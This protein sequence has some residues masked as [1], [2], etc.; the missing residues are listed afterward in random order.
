[1]IAVPDQAALEGLSTDPEDPVYVM[2]RRR[3][4]VTSEEI[5]A[6]GQA[7]TAQDQDCCDHQS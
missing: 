3:R 7:D 1:M 6:Q 2:W 4:S 5:S